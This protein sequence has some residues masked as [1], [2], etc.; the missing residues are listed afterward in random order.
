[1]K[2]RG[3]PALAL[4]LWALAGAGLAAEALPALPEGVRALLDAKKYDEA[5][6]RLLQAMAAGSADERFEWQKIVC[7]V[8][9]QVDRLDGNLSAWLDAETVDAR[10]VWLAERL[11][12]LRLLR[13]DFLGAAAAF[14]RGGDQPRLQLQA[15]RLYLLLG[16]LAGAER[17]LKAAAASPELA[18]AAL[19][20]LAWKAWADGKPKDALAL[21]QQSQGQQA[22]GLR[23][24]L[25]RAL[26]QKKTEQA[27]L[28]ALRAAYPHSVMY[29]L[30]DS[31][32]DPATQMDTALMVLLGIGPAASGAPEV[33]RA[34]TA[35]SPSA[36]AK[37]IQV[38]LF[39]SRDN[40]QAL[41]KRLKGKGFLSQV[42]E[43]KGSSGKLKVVVLIRPGQDAQT[44]L[45][46]L[47]DIGVEGFLDF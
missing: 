24:L 37:A 7:A 27:A 36:G 3:W 12:D 30:V 35:E 26:G 13:R 23:C 5:C 29:A 22:L 4:C 19:C 43:E 42:V 11:G 47:K 1:M 6:G 44:V 20:A 14:D 39:K 21:A 2:A 38:G 18:D 34:P 33:E 25:A 8:D 40:A 15:G 31:D 46:Q 45:I 28:D 16:D 32:S 10:R 9:P 41:A 17:R